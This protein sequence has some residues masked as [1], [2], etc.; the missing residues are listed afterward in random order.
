MQSFTVFFLWTIQSL[1]TI[2]IKIILYLSTPTVL[3]TPII[4]KKQFFQ[5][6]HV[7][8]YKIQYESHAVPDFPLTIGLMLQHLF[9][10]LGIN[11]P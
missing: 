1:H 9:F 8:R 4:M 11:L 7:I 10:S 2:P 6:S 5:F 3:L